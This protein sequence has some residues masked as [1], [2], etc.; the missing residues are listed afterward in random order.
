MSPANG[1]RRP[2]MTA[3]AAIPPVSI[4]T[5]RLLA[6]LSPGTQATVFGV[7]VVFMLLGVYL[8]WMLPDYRMTA[9]ER[10]KEGR[11][12]EL[13]ARRRIAWLRFSSPIV[14]LLGLALF[15]ALFL[16]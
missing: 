15:A 13:Q 14:V 8:R 16:E 3:A 12:T 2:P 5:L 4:G 7:G 9:E 11:W 1:Y 6:Q 10:T